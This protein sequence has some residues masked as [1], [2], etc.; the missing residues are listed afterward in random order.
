MMRE[1]GMHS[2]STARICAQKC[3]KGTLKVMLLLIFA[4]NLHIAKISYAV[5]ERQTTCR[6]LVPKLKAI[7]ISLF[8]EIATFIKKIDQLYYFNTFHTLN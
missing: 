3:H 7:I 4:V 2:N 1:P 5:K 6:L 8:I